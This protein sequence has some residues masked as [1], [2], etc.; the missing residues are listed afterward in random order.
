MAS[1]GG[2]VCTGRECDMDDSTG[3]YVRPPT[4]RGSAILPTDTDR[5]VGSSEGVLS[6]GLDWLTGSLRVAPAAACPQLVNRAPVHVATRDGK[7]SWI[8]PRED[9]PAV[10]PGDEQAAVALMIAAMGGYQVLGPS[11]QHST[12]WYHNG[13]FADDKSWSVEWS[14]K[15]RNAGSVVLTAKG[16]LLAGLPD[17][18]LSAC[19]SLVSQ[20]V[21]VRRVDVMAEGPIV[22]G[23]LFELYCLL[24]TERARLPRGLSW[25]YNANSRKGHTLYLGSESSAEYVCIYDRRGVTRA[26]VRGHGQVAETMVRAL[27]ESGDP[28]RLVVSRL[29]RY[30]GAWASVVGQSL[31]MALSA[32]GPGSGASRPS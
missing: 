7:G 21:R 19:R 22:P 18:G 25:S 14:G 6:E 2:A 23:A 13:T 11:T 3:G 29:G 8:H 27:L 4:E 28:R 30:G 17:R 15:G 31:L 5:W 24:E 9:S 26:E 10:L 20:G 12:Q 1:R 16:K 32:S